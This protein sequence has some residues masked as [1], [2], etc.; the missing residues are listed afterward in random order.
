MNI[1][2]SFNP[3]FLSQVSKTYTLQYTI[4]C[5]YIVHFSFTSIYSVKHLFIAICSSGSVDIAKDE[6]DRC[7]GLEMDAV[8]VDEEG[9]PVFFKGAACA[10]LPLTLTLHHRALQSPVQ[11]SCLALSVDPIHTRSIRSYENALM[12][13]YALQL[14][15]RAYIH[16]RNAT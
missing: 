13:L 9:V 10:S 5:W 2:L 1:S 8:A 12:F 16:N 3:G 4:K 11:R 15:Q 14:N 6:L 7:K